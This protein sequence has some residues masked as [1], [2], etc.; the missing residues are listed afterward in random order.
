MKSFASHI[1]TFALAAA[2]VTSP[3][4]AETREA[5]ISK[6]APEWDKHAQVIETK[7]MAF[8][9]AASY[10]L[11]EGHLAVLYSYSPTM[12]VYPPA[13][14]HLTDGKPKLNEVGLP[15]GSPS[16]VKA[17]VPNDK[18]IAGDKQKWQACFNPQ[19]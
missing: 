17:L 6:L 1:S 4:I 9:T 14:L 2:T 11:S 7:K 3:A 15:E 12:H 8:G 16:V 5:C 19:P 18:W 13:V 10:R